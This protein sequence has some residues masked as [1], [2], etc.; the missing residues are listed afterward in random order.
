MS[1]TPPR[2]AVQLWRR[3]L[4]IWA[5]LMVLLVLTLVVAYLPLGAANTALGL[6]I[7]AAK[8]A[9]VVLL[10]MEL[11]TSPSLVRLA[12]VSGLVFATILFALTL[13]DVLSRY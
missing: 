11:I 4:V 10:F 5:A 13:A 6:V 3:N 12:A 7:A 8:A 2:T 1:D 9:L